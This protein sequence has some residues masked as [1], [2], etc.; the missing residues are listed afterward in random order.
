MADPRLE[1]RQLVERSLAGRLVHPAVAADA[2]AIG[3]FEIADQLL[4]LRFGFRRKVRLNVDLADAFAERVVDRGNGALP[5]LA[6]LLNAVQLLRI[7]SELSVIK[8]L[9]KHVRMIRDEA[10]REPFLPRRKRRRRQDLARARDRRRLG[11]DDLLGASE[12]RLGE[13]R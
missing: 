11:H 6:L 8:R 5:A 7:E 2:I 10:E 1:R 9:W 4:H 3:V 13:R 12:T